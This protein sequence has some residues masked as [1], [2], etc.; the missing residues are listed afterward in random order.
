VLVVSQAFHPNVHQRPRKLLWEAQNRG[1]AFVVLSSGSGPEYSFFLPLAAL[2]WSRLRINPIILL[3]HDVP[4][5]RLWGSD[6]QTAVILRY[7]DKW[8][9]HDNIYYLGYNDTLPWDNVAVAQVARLL[10]SGMCN[11]TGPIAAAK[12]HD[13]HIVTTDVDIFPVAGAKYWL[14]DSSRS[15]GKITN[16]HCCAANTVLGLTSREYPMS[17]MAFRFSK[18]RQ[19]MQHKCICNGPVDCQ[20]GSFIAYTNQL[21]QETFFYGTRQQTPT[22]WNMDQRLASYMLHQSPVLPSTEFAK[23]DTQHDRID[24][25]TWPNIDWSSDSLAK[26]KDAHVLRPGYTSGNWERLWKLIQV[27]V[28]S[29][30]DSHLKDDIEMYVQEY[31]AAVAVAGARYTSFPPALKR[32]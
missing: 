11:V 29:D 23:R 19:V 28:V 16:S 13:A 30:A 27:L 18:W 9:F 20:S 4:H 31:Q 8:G 5:T 14:P 25:L 32:G 3:M 15:A 1:E 10:V 6:E 21:M 24:R 12:V 7:L 2:L 26:Y 22:Q 17:T